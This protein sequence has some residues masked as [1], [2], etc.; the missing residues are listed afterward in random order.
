M[1]LV[2]WNVFNLNRDVYAVVRFV[3]GEDAD[4][5]ALQ[6]LTPSHIAALRDIAGYTLHTAEDFAEG[7]EL[8]YLGLF[9]R[10]S[11]R[12]HRVITHNPGRAVSPSIV[13]R[14]MKWQECFQSQSI[15]VDQGGTEVRVANLHLSCAVSPRARLAQLQA[16][17]P[18]IAAA[19]R[20]VVC[21]DFNSFGRPWISPIV[22]WLYGFGW[23]DVF[24]DEPRGLARYAA[25]QGMAQVFRGVVTFPRYGFHLDH[26]LVRGLTIGAHRVEH[27]THGSDHRPIVAELTL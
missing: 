24:R 12:D 10:L 16:A 8:T 27:D 26:M 21:G 3:R 11:A 7:G 9:T 23:Q 18:H 17:A 20:A 4:V 25:A 13:G 15:T 5:Y 6:E 22:G 1:K 2:S 19:P 14:R